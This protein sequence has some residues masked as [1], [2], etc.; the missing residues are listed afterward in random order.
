MIAGAALFLHGGDGVQGLA[1]AGFPGALAHV[2][3]HAVG[4]VFALGLIEAGA[5]AIL[6]ISASTG[7]AAAES[8][9]AP[10]SMNY[11]ARSAAIFYGANIGAAAIA[12]ATILIPGAPLL[13]IALNANILA[14]I[15]L[16]VALVFVIMLVNDRQLMGNFVN[17]RLH[18]VVAGLIVVFVAASGTAYAVDSFLRAVHII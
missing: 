15:L 14:T 2:S 4:A 11:T 18:N 6:T 1:G 13:S 7:Y 9:G 5:V 16:P 8:V 17:G 10:H 12:A 3:G